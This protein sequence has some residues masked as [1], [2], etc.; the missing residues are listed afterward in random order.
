MRVLVAEDE[1]VSRLRLHAALASWGYEVIGVDDG[2]QA[3][4]VLE[5]P[6]RPSL[7]ILDWSMPKMT[8]LEVCRSIRHAAAGSADQYVYTI[9]LTANDRPEDLIEGFAAGADDYVTKPFNGNELKAR[10][11]TGARIIELHRQLFAAR[12]ELRVKAMHDSLTGLLNRGAYV[13][14]YQREVERAR[15]QGHALTLIMAD[16]DRFKQVNDRH[17]HAAGDDVLREAARRLRASV[18]VSDVTGRF[19]GEE[20]VALAVGCGQD[21]GLV[22]AERFRHAMSSN[23]I[24]IPGGIVEVTTSV[25][26]ATIT[27]M[28]KSTSLFSAAD[29]ALYRAKAKG[30]NIVEAA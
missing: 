3:L 27:D 16:L 15:R 29:E 18:R 6:D 17:G 26:V 28:A 19:G 5:Q 2:A 10:I 20:F 24:D 12:E 25:G 30:R 1:P 23:P 11:R 8:G 4:R 22:L 21:H 14:T 7:A 9:L 13:E